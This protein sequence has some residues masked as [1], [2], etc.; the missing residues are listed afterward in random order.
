MDNQPALLS[1]DYDNY[2]PSGAKV[3]I[4]D[5]IYKFVPEGS[6]PAPI[7]VSERLPELLAESNTS[8]PV[9]AYSVDRKEWH[10]GR[11]AG[12]NSFFVAP[13]VWTF[14]HRAIGSDRITHWLPL[15]PK[16][17]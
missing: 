6:W 9:L 17:Q 13:P 16:P 5:E 11:L 1:V 7:S 4:E 12:V 10:V 3:R 14:D 8:I 2:E 15:P